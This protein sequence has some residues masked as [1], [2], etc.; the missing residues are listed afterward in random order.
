MRKREEDKYSLDNTQPAKK[1]NTDAE[2]KN[3]GDN[4]GD[5]LIP[6]NIPNAIPGADVIPALP[7]G[8]RP[9]DPFIPG[10]GIIP[11]ALITDPASG[12]ANF[13]RYSEY[14]A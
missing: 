12:S 13:P 10:K 1:V 6:E 9:G 4:P 7:S 5:V 2:K 11:P 3:I 8:D 14:P